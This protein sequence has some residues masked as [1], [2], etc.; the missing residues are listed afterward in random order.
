MARKK[1]TPVQV[2]KL[3][4]LNVVLS[5]IERELVAEQERIM[6]YMGRERKTKK[7]W[8][9]YCNIEAE[10]SFYRKGKHDPLFCIMNNLGLYNGGEN[11]NELPIPELKHQ[12]HC[13]LMHDLLG[14]RRGLKRINDVMEIK[15]INVEIQ[16]T[17]NRAYFIR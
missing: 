17:K 4:K 16:I 3:E 10:I 11:W 12:T 2:K 6:S 1:L 5:K 9:E 13:F 15:T 14:R 8:S 7:A